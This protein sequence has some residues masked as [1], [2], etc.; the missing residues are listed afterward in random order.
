LLPLQAQDA[1]RQFLQTYVSFT[2]AQLPVNQIQAAT[3]E[4]RA[5]IAANPPNVPRTIHR[6]H[7]RI[8]ALAIVPAQIVDAGAGWAAT[9]EVDDR[10]ETYRVTVKLGQLH[11]RWLVIALLPGR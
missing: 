3:P 10:L 1:A 11:G 9:A 5:H 2:Y 8:I 7:P 4:L 6:L